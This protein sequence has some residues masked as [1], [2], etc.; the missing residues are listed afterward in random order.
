M[1]GF[2]YYMVV[3]YKLNYYICRTIKENTYRY[4][5]RRTLHGG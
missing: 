3:Q 4:G 1:W 5:D 2:F